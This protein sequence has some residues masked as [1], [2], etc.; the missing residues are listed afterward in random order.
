MKNLFTILIALLS[1]IIVRAQEKAPEIE[2]NTFPW[3][4]D[5]E[6]TN[7]LAEIGWYSVEGLDLDTHVW[8][9]CSEFSNSGNNAA[10]H[11]HMGVVLQEGWLITPRLDLPKDKEFILTF[12]SYNHYN[13]YYNDGGNRVFISKNGNGTNLKYYEELWVAEEVHG[14]WVERTV[15]IPIEYSGHKVYMA[16]RYESHES[17][18]VSHEW[19]IDD[20]NIKENYTTNIDENETKMLSIYPN[21]SAGNITV[22]LSGSSEIEIINTSGKLVGKYYSDK[23]LS[24][25]LEI[26]N[27]IY[28]IRVRDDSNGNTSSQRLIINK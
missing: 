12:W 27:G 17:S 5:F 9:M 19:S 13:S 14:N 15:H 7:S 6:S 2:I 8:E 16:F 3:T 26:P 20:I 25:N 28:L 10:R 1:I 18:V 21:P 24:L 22:P 4:E 23:T 11:K